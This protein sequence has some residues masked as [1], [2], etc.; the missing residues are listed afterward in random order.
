MKRFTV[1]VSPGLD[2]EVAVW[3]GIVAVVDGLGYLWCQHCA[4]RLEKS[5]NPVYADA[6]PHNTES[7]ESCGQVV[8]DAVAVAKVA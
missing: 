6:N 1:T 4:S 2:V 8:R 5:G 7:C 3:T